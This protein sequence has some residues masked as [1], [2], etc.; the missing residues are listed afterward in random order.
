MANKL[1]V[2][3]VN[4]TFT[5]S[6]SI[7]KAPP[8]IPSSTI[9][10]PP[11][12]DNNLTAKTA[13]GIIFLDRNA[14]KDHYKSDY[15]RYNLKQKLHS[16]PLI[17]LDEFETYIT[18]NNNDSSSS[19]SGSGSEDEPE[20]PEI[21]DL[22]NKTTTTTA[23]TN[24]NMVTITRTTDQM[25]FAIWNCIALSTEPNN[26]LA[27]LTK[28]PLN[29]IILLYT[30]GHFSAGIYMN[31]IKTI[32]KTIHRYTTRRKQG[33]SQAS[34]DSSGSGA[35]NSAGAQIRRHNEIMLQKEV[36]QLLSVDWKK[37]MLEADTIFLSCTKRNADLFFG[38]NVPGTKGK[39]AMNKKDV[40]IS[41][42]PF[43]TKRPTLR[44]TTRVC[45]LLGRLYLIK[46]NK[47]K[48]TDQNMNENETEEMDV[49]NTGEEEKTTFKKK[50]K[51][52]KKKNKKTEEL[53]S[54]EI[55]NKMKTMLLQ[56]EKKE[57][58]ITN[59]Y[60][61][62][63]QLLIALLSSSTTTRNELQDYLDTLNQNNVTEILNA[64]D[65]ISGDTCLHAAVH[66]NQYKLITLLLTKGTNPAIKNK[67]YSTPFKLGIELKRT[68]C[69]NEFR[70]YMSNHPEQYDYK[71]SNIEMA[72]GLSKQ[73]EE[74]KALKKKESRKRKKMARKKRD[75]LQKIENEMLLDLSSK[76]NSK[77]NAVMDVQKQMKMSQMIR[78]VCIELNLNENELLQII[79]SCED[80]NFDL[81]MK[82]ASMLNMGEDPIR[83]V[84]RMLEGTLLKRGKRVEK[85]VG[86]VKA[87]SSGGGG[88]VKPPKKWLD[89]NSTK[90]VLTEDEKR[91]ERRRKM[92]AAAEAR[93]KK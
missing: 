46:E 88:G 92:A 18:Q 36:H 66:F 90:P 81:L 40:R 14:L 33:G 82:C 38:K 21:K 11:I 8:A 65:V 84:G 42:I 53:T 12:D 75:E 80:D 31:G 89:K 45:E 23:S 15:H 22:Q 10:T 58:I 85:E 93:M 71:L 78:N 48:E 56:E 29:W 5:S 3:S 30:S 62:E 54:N 83:I 76:N 4:D 7:L 44:E 20:E 26:P 52:K 50:K 19:L 41:R 47:N 59:A 73:D 60:P 2:W 61:M 17:S 79:N 43:Q 6:T 74:A 9:T 32:S 25:S 87:P 72:G 35:A 91:M 16:K 13:P 37:N 70:R 86:I 64:Q 49:Q 77:K 34:F 63:H 24:S 68:E 69:R 27:V 28:K 57:V 55:E 39:S 1:Y 67:N 51:K